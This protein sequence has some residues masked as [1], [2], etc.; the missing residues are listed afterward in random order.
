M[1]FSARGG[2]GG[3]PVVNT[4]SIQLHMGQAGG[5][6][7]ADNTGNAANNNGGPGDAVTVPI[8]GG[9]I[10]GHFTAGS[11]P[12]QEE[13]SRMIHFMLGRVAPGG[14]PQPGAQQP[15][16][17]QQQQQPSPSEARPSAPGCKLSRARCMMPCCLSTLGS[18][19][20]Q[21]PSVKTSGELCVLGYPRAP[22]EQYATC[23]RGRADQTCPA[24]WAMDGLTARF[25]GRLRTPL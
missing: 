17:Q 5:G 14:Q 1:P 20:M 10:T 3:F 2:P 19:L 23:R 25:R 12:S 24:A 16:R 22:E 15:P 11:A 9:V 8:P 6:D 4:T 7:V 18:S 13:F 21:Y